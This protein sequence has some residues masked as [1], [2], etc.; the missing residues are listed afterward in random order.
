MIRYLALFVLAG[1]ARGAVTA[2]DGSDDA[3][4]AADS[5]ASDG[6][7]TPA[8]AAA[9]G[10]DLG[11]PSSGPFFAS[12][13]EEQTATITLAGKS[14]GDLWPSCWSDDDNLY[15]ANGDGRAFDVATNPT[16]NAYDVAVSR[17][18]GSP[19]APSTLAGTTR[20]TSAALASM[21]SGTSYNRKPTGM[22]CR[23]GDLYVAVQDLKTNTFDDAPAASISVSHDKGAT[24][25]WNHAA[26]M[27]ANHVFTTLFFL[28]FG[29]DAADAIDGYVYVY[30]ID[31][32]WA[33]Q[34]KLYLA[35]V[36]DGSVLDRSAWTFFAGLAAD[37]T[38]RFIAD[39]AARVPVLEDDRHLYSDL[40]VSGYN[41]GGYN[42]QPL[43]QG[44]VVY[45]KPGDAA[46]EVHFQRRANSR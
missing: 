28:D 32:S 9:I 36:P 21:W 16:P 46:V 8:D 10:A 4:D 7:T 42:M 37:G 24:W 34:A 33:T 40:A 20:A 43:A 13:A 17:I 2:G 12:A 26:P 39:I 1:C 38:P 11:P 25:T 3:S 35:R 30:G 44:S 27:F 14:E 23:H 45:D 18:G 41:A 19:D 22:L 31:Q 29:K 6:G 15:A 5:H